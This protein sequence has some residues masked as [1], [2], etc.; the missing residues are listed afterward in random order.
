LEEGYLVLVFLRPIDQ[1]DPPWHE[2]AC[3]HGNLGRQGVVFVVKDGSVIYTSLLFQ[4]KR[5][6]PQVPVCRQ[7]D[8]VI[9][10]QAGTKPGIDW[11]TSSMRINGKFHQ[12]SGHLS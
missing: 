2:R 12:S 9:K 1:S 10:V 8:E 4:A 7:I 3:R 11:G 5:M 6:L